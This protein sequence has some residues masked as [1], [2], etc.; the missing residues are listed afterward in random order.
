MSRLTAALAGLLLALAGAVG[1]AFWGYLEG[2]AQGVL[3][4]SSKRHAQALQDLTN[5]IESHQDLIKQAGAASQAMRQAIA[6]R[7]RHDEQTTKE[8]R[9]ALKASAG[10]RAGCVFSADVMRQLAAA[11]DRAAAAAA[12][13]VRHQVPGTAA[14]PN[15]E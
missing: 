12:G 13:G 7:V 1:G 15:D 4:E 9:D 14:G 2:H 11:R 3:A 10:S 5:L 6:L 8:F